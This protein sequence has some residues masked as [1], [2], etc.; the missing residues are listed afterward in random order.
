MMVFR[1]GR[2]FWLRVPQ[3]KGPRIQRSA[4]TTDGRTARAIQHLLDS[5]QA[6]RRWRLLDAAARGTITVGELYDRR[7]DLDALELE[8][9]DIDVAPYVAEWRPRSPKYREQIRSLIPSGA[10]FPRSRLTRSKIREWLDGLVV[11]GST[12][13]RYRSALSSFCSY[14][15]EREVL[16]RNVVRD[17]KRDRENPARVRWLTLDRVTA[18]LEKTSDPMHR[19]V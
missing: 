9:D 11:S 13:N 10:R 17:V 1:R 7:A 15:V 18:L 2:A 16:Q 12:R 4:G 19:C 6:E 3:S 8:L 5:L 14:L